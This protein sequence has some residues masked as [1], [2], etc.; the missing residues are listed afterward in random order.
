MVLILCWHA[1]DAWTQAFEWIEPARY[2]CHKTEDELKIDGY[3]MDEAWLKVP[4]TNWFVDIEGASRPAPQYHTRAKMLWNDAYLYFAFELEEPHLWATL[5]ERDAVIYHDNDIEIFIDANGDTHNYIELELNALNT[6]WDL[7]LPMPYREGGP[8]LNEFDL[9]GLQTAV[10][11]QGTLNCAADRDTSWTVEVAIP[12]S[13]LLA[14]TAHRRKPGHGESMR[15]NFSRVQWDLEVVDG[16]YRKATDGATGKPLPEHNWVWSPMGVI[17][18]H[19]PEFWGLVYFAE[20]A[21]G[22]ADP[23]FCR[24]TDQLRQLLS[25]VYKLQK[26]RMQ[27]TGR[28]A[29]TFKALGLSKALYKS[30]R[31]KMDIAGKMFEIQGS[32]PGGAFVYSCNHQGKLIKEEQLKLTP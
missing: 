5:T 18:M 25:H 30:Y 15:I 3:L 23:F 20:D 26:N 28:Y 17:D 7:F 8:A 13:N 1:P 27:H 4:W 21:T 29:R 16:Q 19:R 10:Q 24:E 32:I 14:T 9:A 31:L 11:L 22:A 12:W 2:V 6:V